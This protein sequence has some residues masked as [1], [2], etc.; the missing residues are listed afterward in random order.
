M[1]LYFRFFKLVI[2]MLF[3]KHQSPLLPSHLKFRV[4]PT[5]LD[6]FSHITNSRY[7]SFMDL[8]RTHLLGQTG[9]LLKMIKKKY[10]P[11]VVSSEISYIKQIGPFKTFTLSSRL[12]TWDDNN[13]YV[14]QKFISGDHICAIAHVR[15]LIL[16]KGLRVPLDDVFSLI[17]QKIPRPEET[18]SIKKWKEM[19]EVKKVYPF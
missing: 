17:D 2:K 18:E 3:L 19:L 1:N 13:W 4:W 15:G 7:F 11:I 9:V 16:K 12:L 10:Y 14:Q 6:I 8:G 5:D